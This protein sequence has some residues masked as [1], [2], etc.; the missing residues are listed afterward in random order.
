MKTTRNSANSA[1]Q[2]LSGDM[3]TEGTILFRIT[4]AEVDAMAVERIVALLH[5]ESRGLLGLS[6]LLGNVTVTLPE[7]QARHGEPFLCGQTRAYCQRLY[8]ALPYWG[9]FFS[10]KSM[11]LWK[12]SLGLLQNTRVMQF[13]R[14]CDTKFGFQ[15]DEISEVVDTHIRDARL[16]GEK[17]LVPESALAAREEALRDYFGRLL[18]A[19]AA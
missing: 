6:Y 13:E 3:D 18:V 16:L 17:G 1:P 5:P 9:F 2:Y 19:H 12:L 8:Q 10:V 11:A 7:T 14:P 15:G 4:K